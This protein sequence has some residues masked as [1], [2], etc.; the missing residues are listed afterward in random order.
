M[1]T[2]PHGVSV[3]VRAVQT[4]NLFWS[5][6]VVISAVGVSLVVDVDVDVV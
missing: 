3:D 6:S 1:K 5:T 4:A 2:G